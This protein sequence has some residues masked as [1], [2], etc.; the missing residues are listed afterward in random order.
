MKKIFLFLIFLTY[1]LIC[2]AQINKIKIPTDNKLKTTLDSLVDQ[3]VLVFMKNNS[4]VG[5]SIGIIKNGKQYIYNYGSTQ[6][7]KLE[8]P[9][10]N[11]VY[12]LASIT[13]TFASTL[14]AK[15]VIEN[16]VKLNDDIRKY[17]KEDYP[18]LDNNGTPITLLNLANLTS[19]LPNWMP[20]KDLFGKANPDDIPYI[21]D[22]VHKKYSRQDFY[23]DLHNVKLQ[24]IPGTVS[25][26][27]NTAA[28][29]LGYI[30]E[31]VYND[32]YEN[33]LK[34]YF[35][36]PLKMKNTFLLKTGKTPAK[37]A[38][39]YDGKG[40]VMPIIDWEDLRVAAS[41]ASS[42]SDMLKYMTFQLNEKNSIVKLS[43]EPTFGKIEDGAIALNWKVKKT[44]NGRSISHTG[45]SLG[46][47]S[48]IVFYPDLNSGIILLSNEADQGT[49]NELITLSN[50]I[51]KS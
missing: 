29:L 27:C 36:D 15:A 50:E 44:N 40:R 16:K 9:T 32:S 23:R 25:R 24:T 34:M 3:S 28:Q 12:E 30:M 31:E 8:L 4:R 22:S 49:Q 7:E 2:S 35:V 39:G 37:M 10:S 11:T 33:L 20:D 46:F 26:H 45:G 13:K 47:S 19:G 48:Y 18:N 51:L 21:L 14:L 41:I 38:K 17:L 43:H 42:T 6:K 5:I 1:P